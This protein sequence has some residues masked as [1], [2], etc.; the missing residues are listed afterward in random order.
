M[1]DDIMKF[2]HLIG[3]RDRPHSGR[4]LFDHL[5]GTSNLL[6]SWG[7]ANAVCDAGLYHSVYGT[8]AFRFASVPREQRPIIRS[9][10]GDEAE[11][12]A[13]LFGSTYRPWA[14]LE[15][16]ETSVL[17]DRHTA[18]P[19][20]IDEDTRAKLITIECA[21]LLEQKKGTTFLRHVLTAVE[22]GDFVLPPK[23]LSAIDAGW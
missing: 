19:I 16:V 1:S 17:L 15:W 3:T 14:L 9:L 12:L 13:F 7:C 18:Q 20:L 11:G 6:R 2:L 22:D 4:T 10:I 8:N 23:V 21:N 5:A